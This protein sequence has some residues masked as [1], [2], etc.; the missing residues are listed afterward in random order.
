MMK[1]EIKIFIIVLIA[2]IICSIAWCIDTIRKNP[3]YFIYT[4]MLLIWTYPFRYELLTKVKKMD[5]EISGIL[6][7]TEEQYKELKEKA[8]KE[9]IE[10]ER[11]DTEKTKLI[12]RARA[13]LNKIDYYSL[14]HFFSDLINQLKAV[15]FFLCIQLTV[16]DISPDK[17]I[18]IETVFSYMIFLIVDIVLCLV[19]WVIDQ[20]IN[21]YN[22]IILIEKVSDHIEGLISTIDRV[23]TQ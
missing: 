17:K 18:D 13:D 14:P 2:I 7:K 5:I 10:I 6:Q 4:I 22:S 1:K 3:I 20:H 23:S 15:I 16:I 21:R 12:N 19:V 8:E 11:I 9:I